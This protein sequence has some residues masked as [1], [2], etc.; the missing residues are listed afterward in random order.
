MSYLTEQFTGG[1]LD[2]ARR[3]HAL[4]AAIKSDVSNNAETVVKSAETF[5]AYLKGQESDGS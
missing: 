3:V 2:E 5:E 1:T 4:E